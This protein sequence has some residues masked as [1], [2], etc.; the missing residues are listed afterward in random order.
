MDMQK[1]PFEVQSG[2]VISAADVVRIGDTQYK[3]KQVIPELR[4][5]PLFHVP[6]MPTEGKLPG[7]DLCLKVTADVVQPPS[8][9]EKWLAGGGR[10]GAARK[11]KKV[12][13]RAT[14]VSVMSPKTSQQDPIAQRPTDEA[15]SQKDTSP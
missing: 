12:S 14:K 13:H 6:M 5:I 8:E 7:M 15:A 4:D 10:G 1:E 2:P 9:V 11:V 3:Q